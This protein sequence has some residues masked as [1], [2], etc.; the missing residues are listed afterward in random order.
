MSIFVQSLARL[1]KSG[2]ITLAD[3]PAKWRSQ[4]EALMKGE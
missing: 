4:V 1:C 2:K 3:V